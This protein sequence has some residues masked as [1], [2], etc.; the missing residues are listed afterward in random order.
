M[1]VLQFVQGKDLSSKLIEWFSH[2]GDVS[3]VDVLWPGGGLYGARSDEVGGAPAGVQLRA[4][5][6]TEGCNVVRV[7]LNMS[8]TKR[9]AFYDFLLAQEGKPYD[10]TGILGF[11]V[12]RD[13]QEPDSWFCSELV[14]A[15][16]SQC[17]YFDYPPAAASNKITPADLLLLVSITTEVT[18]N[19]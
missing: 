1:I 15:A 14:A 11:V 7:T 6:Y 5:N 12:D 17:G 4:E 9:Q 19:S 8:A 2:S 3:H 13:W 16:L 10:K 18:I